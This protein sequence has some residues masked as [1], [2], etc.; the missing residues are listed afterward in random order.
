MPPHLLIPVSQVLAM[1][2]TTMLSNHVYTQ[3]MVRAVAQPAATAG[4]AAGGA[5]VFTISRPRLVFAILKM[6]F[7]LVHAPLYYLS[8]QHRMNAFFERTGIAVADYLNSARAPWVS[9]GRFPSI[10]EFRV[11]TE[12]AV[13]V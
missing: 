5:A 11:R 8:G 3:M 13:L 10:N 6:P 9:C 1:L 7:R 4:A 2:T 12:S